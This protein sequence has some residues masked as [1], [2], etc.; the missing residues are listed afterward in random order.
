MQS[1]YF[2]VILVQTNNLFCVPWPYLAK[3]KINKLKYYAWMNG[4]CHSNG[5]IKQYNSMQINIHN[6][7][8]S[9]NIQTITLLILPLVAGMESY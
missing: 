5:T 6:Y 9:G 4:Q 3:Q 7:I 2:V 1:Y 8:S